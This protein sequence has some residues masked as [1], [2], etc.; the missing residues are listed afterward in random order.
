MIV[1]LNSA[2]PPNPPAT[3]FRTL[4]DSFIRDL[5]IQNP[6]RRAIEVCAE[7]A[8]QL[9]AFLLERGRPVDPAR[10]GPSDVADF[11]DHPQDLG[12]SPLSSSP[13]RRGREHVTPRRASAGHLALAD[14]SPTSGTGSRPGLF[15]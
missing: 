12:R 8:L 5:R 14:G 11:L 1:P 15:A 7:S 3:P 2:A 4:F 9:G 13:R 10:I 6:S